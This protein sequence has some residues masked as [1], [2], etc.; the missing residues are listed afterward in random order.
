MNEKT[1]FIDFERLTKLLYDK[2][3]NGFIGND[4]NAK[5]SITTA[6]NWKK[7]YKMPTEQNLQLINELLEP[8]EKF[9]RIDGLD[10]LLC[11]NNAKDHNRG[12]NKSLPSVTSTGKKVLTLLILGRLIDEDNE[13]GYLT[14]NE[15][16][17]SDVWS[18]LAS[19]NKWHSKTDI[20]YYYPGRTVS[21]EQLSAIRK[22]YKNGINERAIPDG[23]KELV[24]VGLVK[25]VGKNLYKLDFNGC[26]KF[27][28]EN[29]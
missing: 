14:A 10:L 7:Y 17:N 23:L 9:T 4:T 16:K 2:E 19:F 8:K 15:Q 5:I 18:Y 20:F 28:E 11:V 29:K 21:C 12:K 13:Q 1:T 27:L 24:R 25:C 22:S 6:K 26:K 3:L